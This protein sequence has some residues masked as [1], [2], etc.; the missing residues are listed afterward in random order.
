MQTLDLLI[1]YIFLITIIP[2]CHRQAELGLDETW[3]VD[4]LPRGF[5]SD[6][7]QLHKKK[8]PLPLVL[9]T[10]VHTQCESTSNVGLA[11]FI[12][13]P[14]VNRCVSGRL[15]GFFLGS[16]QLNVYLCNGP[17]RRRLSAADKRETQPPAITAPVCSSAPQTC[18][19][20]MLAGRAVPESCFFFLP[21]PLFL[22]CLTPPRWKEQAY[23]DN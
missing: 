23:H 7:A 1:M 8:E 12:P 18:N 4:L 11:L 19:K 2:H 10:S 20:S 3:I 9:V 17:A 15:T 5:H 21:P 22:S 14:R 6:A 16:G 13:V